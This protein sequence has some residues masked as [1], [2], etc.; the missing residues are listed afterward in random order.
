MGRLPRKYTPKSD[1]SVWLQELD[2]PLIIGEI[3]NEQ[4]RYRMLLHA[5]A[6]ACLVVELRC[7]ESSVRPFIVAIYLTASLKVERY[8][9]MKTEG[10]VPEKVWADFLTKH[11]PLCLFS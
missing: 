7:P 6:L 9:I 2:L 3:I 10:L 1:F 11:E 5:N 8:I 4:D